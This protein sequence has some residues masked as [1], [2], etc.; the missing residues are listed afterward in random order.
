MT[1][2][3]SGRI[4]EA[5]HEVTG[6]TIQQYNVHCRQDDLVF[7]RMIFAH[8]G[9]RLGL[10][11]GDIAQDLNVSRSIIYH[12]MKIYPDEVKYN[13]EFRSMAERVDKILTQ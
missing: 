12:Y 11:P 9:R 6:L 3:I 8:Q 1:L 2:V 7:A 13:A 4:Q 10:H 5:F